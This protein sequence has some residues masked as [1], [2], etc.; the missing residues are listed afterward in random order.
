MKPRIFMSLAALALFLPTYCLAGDP[1]TLKVAEAERGFDRNDN[2]ALN[3]RLTENGRHLFGW[4]TSRHVGK[5]VSILIDGRVVMAP[6]VQTPISGGVLQISG[7]SADEI[8]A[9]IPKLLDGRSV[10]SV[11]SED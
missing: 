4:W 10:L 7:R 5:I 8:D 9:W 1:L 2:P 11:D 6:V 3:I